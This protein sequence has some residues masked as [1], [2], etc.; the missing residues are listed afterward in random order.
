[1]EGVFEE[2]P[3]TPSLR[4]EEN[5]AK[6]NVEI[7]KKYFLINKED[8]AVYHFIV[9]EVTGTRIICDSGTSVSFELFELAY[10][11]ED[12]AKAFLYTEYLLPEFIKLKDEIVEYEDL[13]KDK[14]HLFI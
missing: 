11:D 9:V 6:Y 7:G 4:N 12:S 8:L 3:N 10:Q 2:I 5:I 1:M 14:P 13:K